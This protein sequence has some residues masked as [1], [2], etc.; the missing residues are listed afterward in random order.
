MAIMR[1]QLKTKEEIF[2]DPLGFEPWSPRTE[3]QSATKEL[4]WPLLSLLFK[5]L[6][7]K[8]CPTNQSTI[9][10]RLGLV[11]GGLLMEFGVFGVRD[12]IIKDWENNNNLPKLMMMIG[13]LL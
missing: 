11:G 3:T 13:K 10:F 2:S 7:W 4:P 6:S 9:Q 5:R 12:S 1:L 8:F